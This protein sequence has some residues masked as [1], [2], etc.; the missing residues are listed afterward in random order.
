MP[1]DYACAPRRAG[2]MSMPCAK[3]NR[4]W[5]PY[6]RRQPLAPYD[7]HPVLRP[8]RGLDVVGARVLEPAV[9][10]DPEHAERSG[11]G[12]DRRALAHRDRLDARGD[13]EPPAGI[14]RE[15]AHVVGASVRV[16]DRLRLARARIDRENRD[17]VLAPAEYLASLEL[18]RV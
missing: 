10:A 1:R 16:L 13:H 14:E 3:S 9:R 8:A 5:R 12:A 4:G 18:H 17:R 7:P 6:R 15:R 11:H 2:S